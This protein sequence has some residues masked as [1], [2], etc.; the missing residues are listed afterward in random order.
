[1]KLSDELDSVV[2]KFRQIK[3]LKEYAENLRKSGSYNNFEVRLAWDCLR[4]AIGTETICSWYDKYNCHDKHI[5]TLA[6]RALK[7]V[8]E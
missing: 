1:M 6:C 5:T 2:Q 7:I 4:Y 3:N 8:M